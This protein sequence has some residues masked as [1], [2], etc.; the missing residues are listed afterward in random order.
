MKTKAKE[1]KLSTQ[2]T[3]SVS[4]TFISCIIIL[5]FVARTN[6]TN[7]MQKTAQNNMGTSLEAKQTIIENFTVDSESLL[8]SYPPVY[9][10][11]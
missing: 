3:L 4:L 1:K 2:I 10:L 8:I 11:Q 7:V 5:F 6:I 9:Q